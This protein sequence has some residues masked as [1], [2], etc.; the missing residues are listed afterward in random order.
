MIDVAKI[1][2]LSARKV[3][4]LI[5]E[6]P[7]ASECIRNPVNKKL[8]RRKSEENGSVVGCLA[9]VCVGHGCVGKIDVGTF[10]NKR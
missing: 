7:V 6:V 2:M 8:S 5:A 4:E 1:Q 9:R 3:V 10:V